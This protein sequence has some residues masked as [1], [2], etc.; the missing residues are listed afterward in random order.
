MLSLKEVSESVEEED[1]DEDEDEALEYFVV[2]GRVVGMTRV[3]DD[4]TAGMRD[5]TGYQSTRVFGTGKQAS[6]EAF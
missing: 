3:C 2:E 6:P 1:E 5:R 4:A